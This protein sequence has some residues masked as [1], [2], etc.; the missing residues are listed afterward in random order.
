[1]DTFNGHV[2]QL[3]NSGSRIFY[4]CGWIDPS[5]ELHLGL[6]KLYEPAKSGPDRTNRSHVIVVTHRPTTPSLVRLEYRKT[7]A[8]ERLNKKQLV[9]QSLKRFMNV[10]RAFPALYFGLKCRFKLDNFVTLFF[11]A[12]KLSKD[13]LKKS[14]RIGWRPS[15][16]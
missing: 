14:V 2:P 5:F 12:V 9:K 6:T 11:V 15:W 3:V 16:R 8:R 1:M 7:P 13:S 4:I 10:K